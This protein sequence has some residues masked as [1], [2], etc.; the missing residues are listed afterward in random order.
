VDNL[1]KTLIMI[2]GFAI[3]LAV[4]VAIDAVMVRIEKAELK[5]LNKR[6]LA[7]KNWWKNDKY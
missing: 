1:D 4:L 5:R 3:V 6:N 2:I 7:Y